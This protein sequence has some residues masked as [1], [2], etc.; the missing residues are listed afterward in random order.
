MVTVGQATG[1]VYSGSAGQPRV[2][3]VVI[4]VRVPGEPVEKLLH[5][6]FHSPSGMRWGFRGAGPKDLA[7]S[8]LIDA[9]GDAVKCRVCRGGNKVVFDTAADLF[10]AYDPVV[11]GTR[12]AGACGACRHGYTLTYHEESAFE[13]DVVARLGAEWALTDTQITHWHRGYVRRRR[14]A[15]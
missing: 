13:A 3:G 9:L 10:V 15:R 14:Y 7:R 2:G 4:E 11:H 5:R 1:R 12:P 6:L 8:L